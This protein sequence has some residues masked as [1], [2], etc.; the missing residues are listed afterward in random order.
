MYME[1]VG[2]DC[3][4]AQWTRENLAWVAG[5]VE[6]EGTVRWTNPAPKRPDGRHP[7]GQS[8]D[9]SVAMTDEDVLRRIVKIFGVGT[10]FGPY[11]P[12]P[13]TRKP[14]FQLKINGANAYACLMAIW[15][16]LHKR[17][18]D[19]VTIAVKA[20]LVSHPKRALDAMQV[21]HIRE[22]VSK[23]V[24]PTLLANEFGVSVQ[25]I[26]NAAKGKTYKWANGPITSQI[27]R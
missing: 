10:I 15:P 11:Q 21:A 18:R 17:R 26:C 22:E 7:G 2:A 5:I 6:G 12:K 23:G 16:W 25:T 3:K 19:Q 1:S 14:I 20:W 8:L 24:S 13:V 4:S 27:K 9:L